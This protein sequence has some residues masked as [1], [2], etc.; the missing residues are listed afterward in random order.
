[1]DHD[2]EVSKNWFYPVLLFIFGSFYSQFTIYSYYSSPGIIT[3]DTLQ[4]YDHYP[5]DNLL[6]PEGRMDR[7]KGIPRLPRSKFDRLKHKQHVA[8]FD[9]YCGW[10]SATIGAENYR[11]FLLFVFTQFSVSIVIVQCLVLL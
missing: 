5:Y 9:H 6:Y 11:I 8:R 1:M 10:V 2:N 7:K 3:K 4:F